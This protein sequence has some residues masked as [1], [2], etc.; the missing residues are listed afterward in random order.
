MNDFIRRIRRLQKQ[1]GIQRSS[2][3]LIYGDGTERPVGCLE[4]FSEILKDSSIVN[5]K[6]TNETAQSFFS[7]LLEAEQEFGGCFDDLD[8]LRS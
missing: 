8:E 1:L 5:I 6:C 2:V 4:A 3:S 7:T